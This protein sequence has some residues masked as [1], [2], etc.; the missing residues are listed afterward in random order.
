MKIFFSAG[1]ASGDVHGANLAREIK[2]IA[3]DTQ[4]LGFGGNLMENAGVKLVRNYK[5]YN[6][7]G[8]VEVLKN[9]R[10]I[11]NLLNDLTAIIRVENPDL[12]ALAFDIEL[13]TLSTNGLPKK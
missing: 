13:L 11:F 10:R 2:K 8:V 12:R 4:L 5:N 6:I 1:E 9:L 7:M 3:P